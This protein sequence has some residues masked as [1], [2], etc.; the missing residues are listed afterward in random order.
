MNLSLSPA[1]WLQFTDNSGNPLAGGQLYTAQAGTVA[2]PGQ[3]SPLTTYSDPAGQEP[4]AN[5]ITLDTTGRATVYLYGLYSF[6]LYDSN[7]VFIRSQDNVG[8][9]ATNF[10]VL[11]TYANNAAAV[12]AGLSVGTPYLN[13]D[14]LQVVHS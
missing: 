13:G 4:N 9:P 7:G 10:G 12:T 3:A 11:P 6:A 5:P 1:P 14:V 8:Q 2:G